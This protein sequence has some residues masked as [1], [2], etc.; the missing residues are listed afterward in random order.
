MNSQALHSE[1]RLTPQS[2]QPLPTTEPQW[3]EQIHQHIGAQK[4]PG[5]Y[6]WISKTLNT[7]NLI[8]TK[9]AGSLAHKIWFT[10]QNR[11]MSETDKT[12]LK[13]SIA[14][15]LT[16]NGSQVPVYRWGTGPLVLC[17]HGWG[18]HSGQFRQQANSLVE[19]GYSVISFDTPGHGFAEGKTSNLE[20]TSQLIS[21]LAQ[22]YGEFEAII[23]HSIGGLAANNA[24]NNG[25]QAKCTVFL[26]TPMCLDHIVQAFKH[27]LGLASEVV[28]Q[29]RKLMENKFNVGFWQE[30]DLRVSTTR[31]PTFYCYDQQDDQVPPSVGHYLAALHQGSKLVMTEK[32]GHNR[33]VRNPEII[34]QISQF[35][36]QTQTTTMA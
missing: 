31:T 33:S 27:Q 8:S 6:R 35:I 21:I 32:L 22:Q 15:H 17:V 16:M 10:P 9:V 24:I 3:Y 30:Y 13:K 7:T 29:H 2:V 5:I 14:E 20:E 12:W 25:V 34:G 26:N 11:P 28:D 36:Q 4:Q 19:Q 18:G 1:T 23:G